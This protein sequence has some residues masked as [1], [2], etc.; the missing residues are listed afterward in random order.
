VTRWS[1][2]SSMMQALQSMS[3]RQRRFRSLYSLDAS[4]AMRSKMSLTNEFRI[5]IA[6]F[7]I[8]VSGCTCFSTASES[9]LRV[10]CDQQASSPL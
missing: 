7:E 8:P 10:I 2:S 5:A 9:Q 6:L 4:V 1:T 3:E